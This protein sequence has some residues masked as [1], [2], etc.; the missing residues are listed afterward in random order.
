VTSS[1]LDRLRGTGVL[2]PERAAEGA[3]VGPVGRASGQAGDV[4]R[5]RP[6]GLYRELD[7]IPPRTAPTGDAQARLEVRWEEVESSFEIVEGVL[8]LLGGMA[9]RAEWLVEVPAIDGRSIGS[10]E[11]P[12]GETVYVVEVCGGRLARVWP[13]TASFHNLMLFH[14]V[15]G[16]DVFTDFPFIEASF[17]VSNAG[18]VL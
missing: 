14:D 10:V 8:G 17:A 5:D 13:R 2:V 4:R 12:Q 16:G 11:G 15:F 7:L 6:Y 1:F 3:A 18:V 9:G